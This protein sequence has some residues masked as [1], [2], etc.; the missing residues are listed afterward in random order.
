LDFVAFGRRLA[1]HAA[2]LS[3]LDPTHLLP[4]LPGRPR[5]G[6]VYLPLHAVFALQVP[7]TPA[8]AA[9][10]AV[11]AAAAAAAVNGGRG[12]DMAQ[13]QAVVASAGTLGWF[14]LTKGPA[15]TAFP[16][17]RWH[18]PPALRHA[19][20]NAGADPVPS[21][22]AADVPP[23]RAATLK[24]LAD[25]LAGWVV[26]IKRAGRIVF[27]WG[28]LRFRLGAVAALYAPTQR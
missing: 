21:L 28:G 13:L 10:G 5:V 27:A 23:A 25:A 11:S 7:A 20:S 18:L 16:L 15:S 4:G 14:T 3:G 2:R 19:A 6:V 22:R 1:T 17:Q 24:A 9:V 8:T 12:S 26:E